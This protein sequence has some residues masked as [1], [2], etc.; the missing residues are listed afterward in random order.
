MLNHH[1]AGIG[2]VYAYFNY[3][4]AHED[5]GVPAYKVLHDGFFLGL[6]QARVQ[7]SHL[8]W[9]AFGRLQMLQGGLQVF[10]GGGGVLQVERFAFFNQRADPINLPPLLYLFADAGDDFVAPR[11]ADELGQHGGAPWGELVYGADVQIGVVAHGERARDGG[12]SHHEQMR[13]AGWCGRGVL[14]VCVV[15]SACAVL[16]VC[17]ALGLHFLPQSQP[18]LH[19]KAVLLIN[20]GERQI[21][22]LHFV[23]NNGMRAYHQLRFAAGNAR[24]HFAAL[25]GFLAAC[26]PCHAY[27]KRGEPV[28]QLL[29][30]LRGQYFGWRHK[31]T[32]PAST[33]ANGCCQRSHYGFARAHIALQQA[34]HGHWARQIGC[35]FVGYAALGGSQ[36]K[37]QRCQ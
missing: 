18:L 10:V 37:R 22:K 5:A 9:R 32:L 16:A 15:F 21:V 31:R 23:L 6:R 8:R 27:A 12:G 4:G 30:V 36:V 34:V 24:E 2:H 28:E 29:K 19:A 11:L 17:T 20:D 7:Q 35:N 13:L 3:G 14:R 26:E 1:Q 33:Y 25:F